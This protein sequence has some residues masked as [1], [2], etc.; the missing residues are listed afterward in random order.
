MDGRTDGGEDRRS[1]KLCGGEDWAAAGVIES[2][3]GGESELRFEPPPP[4]LE[5]ARSVPDASS[6]SGRSLRGSPRVDPSAPPPPP[7]APSDAGVSCGLRLRLRREPRF[8]RFRPL[9]LLLL[10]LL[11]LLDGAESRGAA[12]CWNRVWSAWANPAARLEPA[13]DAEAEEEEDT[14]ISSV[15]AADGTRLR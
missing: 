13:E 4:G 10:L 1:V 12:R 11:P 2:T 6:G 15:I 9:R 14:G 5:G 3:D 7:P 8:C